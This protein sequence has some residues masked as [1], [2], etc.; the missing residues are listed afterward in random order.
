MTETESSLTEIAERLLDQ[1]NGNVVEANDAF[2]DIVNADDAL[3][4]CVTSPFL[5]EACYKIIRK[6]KKARGEVIWQIPQPTGAE[7]KRQLVV[8]AK[9]SLLDSSPDG[10]LKTGRTARPENGNSA[11]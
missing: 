7:Q 2:M 6:I 8:T 10:T 11:S 5:A 9:L 3:Y 1:N 4:R